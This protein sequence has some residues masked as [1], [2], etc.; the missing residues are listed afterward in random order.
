[1]VTDL[2][3]F[4]VTFEADLFDFPESVE[5]IDTEVVNG[6]LEVDISE[7]VV[8][9]MDFKTSALILMTSLLNVVE[10]KLFLRI[11][12]DAFSSPKSDKEL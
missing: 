4:V 10:N 12:S 11:P 2:V 7:L 3:V 9:G 8:N 1:M 6:G 5:D